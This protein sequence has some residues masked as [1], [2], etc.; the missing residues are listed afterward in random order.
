MTSQITP[1]INHFV[2]ER[3]NAFTKQKRIKEFECCDQVQALN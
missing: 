2:L 3:N 1:S